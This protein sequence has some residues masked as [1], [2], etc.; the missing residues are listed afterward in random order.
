[1]K[2]FLFSLCLLI[3]CTAFAGLDGDKANE[4]TLSYIDGESNAWFTF[5]L[6]ERALRNRDIEEAYALLLYGY[7]QAI[8]E[9]NGFLERLCEGFLQFVGSEDISQPS[10]ELLTLGRQGRLTFE[11]LIVYTT[12]LNYHGRFAESE[13][14]WLRVQRPRPY[15]LHPELR[16]RHVPYNPIKPV[17]VRVLIP[18]AEIRPSSRASSTLRGRVAEEPSTR[19]PSVGPRST[20]RGWQ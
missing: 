20:R 11:Q 18:A 15:D 13:N 5:R 2:P 17:P 10:R 3:S 12:I 1:M 19:W 4:T 6:F 16:R 9:E 14:Y 8:S 7:E